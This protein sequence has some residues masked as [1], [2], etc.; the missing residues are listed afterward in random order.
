MWIDDLALNSL[1]RLA[2]RADHVVP[3]RIGKHSC[4]GFRQTVSLQDINTQVMKIISN[5]RIK[6]RAS[7]RQITHL[8]PQRL[9][10]LAEKDWP[11]IHPD[12]AQ[13]AIEAHQALK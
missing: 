2:H 4:G 6:A 7:G 11:C 3:R 10:H 5:F 13:G 12:L 9:V 1:Q 8:L